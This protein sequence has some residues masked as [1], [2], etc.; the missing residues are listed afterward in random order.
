M[1]TMTKKIT[2]LLSLTTLLIFGQSFFV[3]AQCDITIAMEDSYGDGWNGA[4]I[5]VYD[6]GTLLGTATIASGYT[7]TATISAPDNTD[8]SLVWTAGSYPEECSFTVTNGIGIDVYVCELFENPNPGE[9]FVFT[10]LCSSVGLDV[11]LID[12]II[13]PRVAAGDVEITGIIRSER[14]TP[15]TSFDVLYSLDG[16]NSAVYTFD[17]LDIPFNTTYEFTHPDLAQIAVGEH[18]IDLTVENING[19]GDDDV[20]NNNALSADVLCVN[21]IFPRTVVYEEGTGPWCGWCVRGHI[22]LKDMAHYYDDGSWIGIAVQNGNGNPM[23]NTEYDNALGISSFPSGKMNRKSGTVDPGLSSL[24]PAFNAEA[25]KTPLAKVEITAKTWDVSTREITVDVTS[26]FALDMPSVDYNAS[27]IIVESGITGTSSAYNQ[28]N[29]YASNGIDIFDWEGI[30][31]RNLGNPIPA[32]DMVYNHVGRELV[33]GFDGVAGSIPTAVIYNT[34]YTYTFTHVLPADQ[35]ED[36]IELVALVLDNT[37]GQIENAT[38]MALDYNL[39]VDEFISEIG[40]NAYPNPSTGLLNISTKE[41]VNLSLMNNIGQVV[42][43][44]V[45]VENGN[46][47]DLSNFESGLYFLN[48]SNGL[49]SGMKKIIIK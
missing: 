15:V 8:I 24:E 1:K 11:N 45:A 21:E 20:S 33:G 10:N 41:T 4:S 26:T 22:G 28:A 16:T 32:A 47:I 3:S 5:K 13:A 12:F 46:T 38:Q 7:G 23:V 6:D 43:R 29:Y 19:A 27:L 25:L 44:K 9:F 31:W 17:N 42:Y 34:P 14:D 18:T 30:N 35:N 39:E 49:Q 36:E 40:F 2:L 48:V 37:T